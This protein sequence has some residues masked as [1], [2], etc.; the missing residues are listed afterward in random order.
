MRQGASGDSKLRLP[1]RGHSELRELTHAFNE[2]SDHA[3][4]KNTLEDIFGRYVS[5]Y[6]LSQLTLDPE[7][8]VTSAEREVSI[9][10]ADIRSFTQLAERLEPA[11]VIALLNEFFQLGSEALLQH[12]GTIDK[13]IGDSIMAYFGAP[14]LQAD[15]AERAVAAAIAFQNAVQARTQKLNDDTRPLSVGIGIHSGSVVVGT[16][17]S[18]RRSDYTAIGDAV[19]VASRLQHF[20]AGGEI[21]ISEAVYRRVR[22]QFRCQYAGEQQLEGRAS[23]INLYRVQFQSDPRTRQTA[24]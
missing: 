3:A 2:L 7:L 12:G 21:C 15:H 14:M 4:Q 5:D 9:L 24:D 1:L 10:F 11:E 16:V 20:A 13:F 17:G 8:D 23:P 19:N 18:K 22:G 6:V